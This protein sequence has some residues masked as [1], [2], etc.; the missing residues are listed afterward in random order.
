MRAEYGSWEHVLFW[1]CCVDE[2][3]KTLVVRGRALGEPKTVQLTDEQ[4]AA[5][6]RDVEKFQL[7]S[8]P[9]TDYDVDLTDDLYHMGVSVEARWGEQRFR[10][11]VPTRQL[12]LVP[13]RRL[14]K[15]NYVA[16]SS[17]V[18]LCARR[19]AELAQAPI[20]DHIAAQWKS[21][22]AMESLD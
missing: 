15:K 20:P 9:S 12:V 18:Q 3:S 5:F 13:T 14:T 17:L 10:H 21:R 1:G 19:A 2:A 7:F 16:F 22:S 11:Q 8:L 4:V 6:F